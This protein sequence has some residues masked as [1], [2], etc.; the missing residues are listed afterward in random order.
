MNNTNDSF[1]FHP[2]IVFFSLHQRLVKVL[3]VQQNN[4]Q[5]E[6]KGIKQVRTHRQDQHEF[7]FNVRHRHQMIQMEA[8][9]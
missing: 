7:K 3:R 6:E 9:K 8:M 2:M 5:Q 1:Y 4:K